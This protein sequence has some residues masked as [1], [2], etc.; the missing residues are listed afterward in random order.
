MPKMTKG[1]L[2]PKHA[3]L[4]LLLLVTLYFVLPSGSAET[5]VTAT[6]GSG[7]GS[8]ST[9]STSTGSTSTG[10]TST[11]NQNSV[12]TSTQ[13]PATRS[14]AR[15]QTSGSGAVSA[16]NTQNPETPSLARPI[17]P[18]TEFDIQQMLAHNPFVIF[19]EEAAEAAG[20]ANQ[21]DEKAAEANLQSAMMLKEAPDRELQQRQ[22]PNATQKISMIYRSS[23]G[24]AAA[25]IDGRIVR[26]G[27]TLDGNWAVDQIHE[28][29][30]R[31][32]FIGEVAKP[33]QDGS[34]DPIP[35]K[36]EFSEMAQPSALSETVSELNVNDEP[37]PGQERSAAND[38]EPVDDEPVDDEK[39]PDNSGSIIVPAR[40]LAI[41]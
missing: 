25:V 7:T 17:E 22:V 20:L 36:R 10:S 11:S 19:R 38:D 28:N 18:V 41:P 37:A 23:R 29:T 1:K 35:L 15:S 34:S 3:V 8:T 5:T 40:I 21:S 31:L 24:T 4:I 26:D 9:G 33:L 13:Q 16:G 6:T 2:T 32:R 30:V 27:M 39:E 14:D 12:S